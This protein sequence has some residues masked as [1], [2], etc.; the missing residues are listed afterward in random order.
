MKPKLFYRSLSYSRRFSKIQ[1]SEKVQNK[2]ILNIHSIKEN[3]PFFRIVNRAK[4]RIKKNFIY[5]WKR[6]IR[7]REK[8]LL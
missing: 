5:S 8:Q 2:N 1:R 6:G 3:K 7:V 4:R